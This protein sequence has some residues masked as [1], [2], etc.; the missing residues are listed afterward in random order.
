MMVDSSEHD[1]KVEEGLNKNDFPEEVEERRTATSPIEPTVATFDR[2]LVPGFIER[3]KAEK[4][5]ES[6]GWWRDVLKDKN[7]VI[8]LRGKTLD[9]YWLGARLFHVEFA[10]NALSVSTHEKY[11][12]NPALKDPVF[13]RGGKFDTTRLW[14]NG[15]FGSYKEGETLEE[16][17]KA[18]GLYTNVEKSGC[19]EIFVRNS[20]AVDC[21]IAFPRSDAG[22]VDIAALEQFG[23]DVR[24]VFWEAKKFKN[25]ELRISETKNKK[26]RSTNLE[27]KERYEAPIMPPVCV[28]IARYREYVSTN[29]AHILKSY[30]EVAKNLLE[31]H[32]MGW[33]RQPS[34]LLQAVAAETKRL[35]IGDT[36]KVGLLIFGFDDDQRI[37]KTWLKHR[38]FLDVHLGTSNIIAV[39]DPKNLQLPTKGI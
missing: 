37:G 16:L 15:F 35:V 2:A 21:E 33:R 32:D 14:D 39:G 13:L 26:L 20:S 3:L 12:L 1:K 7:L 9:I 27:D 28:Q 29:Q 11:V 17:K 30:R 31:I 38:K 4:Q 36:P 10:D 22:R 23:Q 19:H 8:A 34:A 25:K 5:T 24:L 18:A 6:G